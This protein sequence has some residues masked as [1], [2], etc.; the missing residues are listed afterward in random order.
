WI[1]QDPIVDRSREHLAEGDEGLLLLRGK[2]FS[3][4][5][6]IADGGEPKGVIRN[7][8]ENQALSLPFTQPVAP[9][10]MPKTEPEAP[11]SFPYLA[12]QPEDAAEAYRRVVEGWRLNNEPGDKPGAS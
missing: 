10:L 4:M 9:Q 5:A 2:L 3:Q 8:I 11:V 7:P 12:G 6:L 1:N